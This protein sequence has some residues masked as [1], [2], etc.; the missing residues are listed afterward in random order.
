MDLTSTPEKKKKKTLQNRSESPDVNKISSNKKSPCQSQKSIKFSD[1]FI[2][3]SISNNLKSSFNSK[4]IKQPE[5]STSPTLYTIHQ[6]ISAKKSASNYQRALINE[7]LDS[8]S[9]SINKLRFNNSKDNKRHSLILKPSA[10][11]NFPTHSNNMIYMSKNTKEEHPFEIIKYSHPLDNFYYNVLDMYDMSQI[12][13]GTQVGII[14]YDILK[15]SKD[16][17]IF[18][19]F[20]NTVSEIHSVKFI[21]KNKLTFSNEN[22]ELKIYDISYVNPLSLYNSNIKRN[23]LSID[24][25]SSN[26]NILF[27]GSSNGFVECIDIRENNKINFL[28][29]HKVNDEVCKVK[30][31]NQNSLLFSGGNDNQ[32]IGF[33]LRKGKV[34]NTFKHKAAI[35]GI[36]INEN[37]NQMASGGGTYDKTIKLWDI[38]K[39]QMI[40]ETIS[41][42]QVTNLEFINNNTLIAGYGYI[43]NNVIVYDLNY[44]KLVINEISPEKLSNSKHKDNVEDIVD[45]FEP[46]GVFE[47]HLKRILYMAISFDKKWL[48]TSSNDGMI[49]IWK[50][51]K[52]IQQNGIKNDS[53]KMR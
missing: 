44:D 3:L 11:T 1:R 28:Y 33:D 24:I 43:G 27:I 50:L 40:S 42:S 41:E 21:E 4:E 49:K 29:S 17:N 26:R 36:A 16:E 46:I 19:H 31:S 38:K 5:L 13:I 51:E 9:Q 32:V 23:I 48:S 7:L 6:I 34:I 37:E 25:T 20:I 53:I 47:K 45:I 18:S 22:G 39:M 30:Y 52:L 15:K 12:C 35:K 14:I 2:P 10:I 8:N